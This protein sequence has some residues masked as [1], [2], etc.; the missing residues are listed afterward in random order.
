[1][2]SLCENFWIEGNTVIECDDVATKEFDGQLLCSWCC[3]ELWN[4]AAWEATWNGDSRLLASMDDW[5][6]LPHL[7]RPRQ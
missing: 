3:S 7:K 5:S 4:D 6:F 1:M 2:L